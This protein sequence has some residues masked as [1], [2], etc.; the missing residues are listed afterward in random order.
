MSFICGLLTVARVR[1][2][3]FPLSAPPSPE[4]EHAASATAETTSPAPSAIARF[5]ERI[6]SPLMCVQYHPC[7]GHGRVA[8]LA[9]RPGDALDRTTGRLVSRCLRASSVW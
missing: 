7:W 8:A 1:V 4:D 9:R 2:T 3:D 6:A 5:L